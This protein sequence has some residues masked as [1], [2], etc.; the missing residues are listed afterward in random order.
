MAIK[1]S[2][3]AHNYK[4][5]RNSSSE[6]EPRK[7]GQSNKVKPRELKAI[8]KGYQ[9]YQKQLDREKEQKQG[10]HEKTDVVEDR[11]MK[12]MRMYEEMFQKKAQEEERKRKLKEKREIKKQ[13]SVGASASK[14]KRD[15]D[16]DVISEA[17]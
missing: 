4:D 6:E 1:M 7:V 14:D 10:K 16:M 12:K 17:N 9:Q 13:L 11:E 5:N 15:E 3:G 8:Q 2:S